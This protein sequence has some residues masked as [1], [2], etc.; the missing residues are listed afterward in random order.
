MDR[1]NR[2]FLWNK[3]NIERGLPMIA[4]DKV[5]TPKILG[6]LGLRKTAAVNCAYQCKLAWKILDG[7]DTLWTTVMR[8]KYLRGQQLLTAV[9]KPGDSTV[10]RSIIKCQEIIRQGIVWILGDGRDI[11]FWKDN[12]VDKKSL[13]DL[14]N[15][16]D[17][18]FVDHNVRVSEFIENKKWNV[19]KLRNSIH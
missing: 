2:E 16:H 18:A 6:G 1:F 17:H 19:L 7:K 9:A 4:W 13:F 8:T 11:S 3:N 5:C 12:W 14:L 15:L 10:W